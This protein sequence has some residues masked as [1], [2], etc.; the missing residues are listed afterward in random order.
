MSK[1]K[2]IVVSVYLVNTISKTF[3]FKSAFQ[4][5]YKVIVHIYVIYTVL[6]ITRQY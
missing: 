3:N 6:V 4:L 5:Y 1:T 2:Q